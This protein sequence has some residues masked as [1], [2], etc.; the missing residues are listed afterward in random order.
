MPEEA[1]AVECLITALK[2]KFSIQAWERGFAAEY[3]AELQ[4]LSDE[5]IYAIHRYV[6]R[7]VD[8]RP[9]PSQLIAI[10]AN[11]TSP[12]PNLDE[13]IAEIREVCN[14]NSGYHECSHDVVRVTVRQLG[15][16]FNIAKSDDNF[17]NKQIANTYKMIADRWQMNVKQQLELPPAQRDMR[18]FPAQMKQIEQK[19]RL[20]IAS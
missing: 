20:E 3:V 1:T 7:N 11:I 14:S 5:E 9:S 19:P 17:L 4:G 13:V 15:G 8:Y 6:R 2:M 18:Y 16:W 12:V 10:A